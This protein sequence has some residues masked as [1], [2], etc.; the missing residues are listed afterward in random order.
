MAEKP[1]SERE[2]HFNVPS[3]E[4]PMPTGATGG[5][6]EPRAEWGEAEVEKAAR[7][8]HE[9]NALPALATRRAEARI[10]LEASGAVP[11]AEHERLRD[12][13]DAYLRSEYGP[14]YRQRVNLYSADAAAALLASA[15]G[16]PD[17]APKEEAR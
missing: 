3:A 8:L 4:A 16:G 12:A 2:P 15:L 7:A 17:D 11:R 10:V 6:S 1:L 14:T 13:V 9:S 5:H